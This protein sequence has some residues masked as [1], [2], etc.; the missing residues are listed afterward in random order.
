MTISEWN[1]CYIT[2][3]E[4]SKT[5]PGFDTIECLALVIQ[6]IYHF[7]VNKNVRCT[8]PNCQG[9]TYTFCRQSCKP[10]PLSTVLTTL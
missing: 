8:P 2:Q 3:L 5:K 7:A 4:T 10:C 9:K 6:V 1:V